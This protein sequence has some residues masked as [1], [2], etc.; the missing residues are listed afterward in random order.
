MNRQTHT[1]TTRLRAT[2][3]QCEWESDAPN[4]LGHAARHH[5]ASGHTVTTDVERRIVYGDEA[6]I[7]PLQ[8]SILDEAAV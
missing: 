4:G 7:D 3:A 8:T 1:V 2:C 5:D 6:A